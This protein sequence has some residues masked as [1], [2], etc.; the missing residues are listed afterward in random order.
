MQTRNHIASANDRRKPARNRA[1]HLVR[2]MR[3]QQVVDLGETVQAN[4]RDGNQAGRMQLRQGFACLILQHHQVADSGH[5]V[6]ERSSN[7]L[8]RVF[9][10]RVELQRVG[11]ATASAFANAFRQSVSVSLKVTGAEKSSRSS[12]TLPSRVASSMSMLCAW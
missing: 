8:L 7:P 9:T 6:A 2:G 4:D 1:Q 3:A 12:P 11:R 5:R 10:D